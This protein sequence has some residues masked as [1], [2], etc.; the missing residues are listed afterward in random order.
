MNVPYDVLR[1]YREG[2][3]KGTSFT[4]TAMGF[5]SLCSSIGAYSNSDLVYNVYTYRCW[6]KKGTRTPHDTGKIRKRYC[7]APKNDENVVTIT[8]RQ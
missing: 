3:S 6:D 4:E 2:I 8:A 1:Q 5:G 7:I